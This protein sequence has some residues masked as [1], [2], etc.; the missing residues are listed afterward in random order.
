[1]TDP[2]SIPN[3]HDGRLAV[4]SVGRDEELL[5]LRKQILTEVGV[6][7]RSVSPERA[8]GYARSSQ[9]RLWIFCS[10][11]ELSSLIYLASSVRRYSPQSKLVLLS[12]LNS[13][14]FEAPLF[15]RILSP[16]TGID[17]FLKTV[18]ELSLAAQQANES[19][20]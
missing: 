8:E 20:N 13:A 1:M 14:K 3:R 12:G 4:I 6:D 15:H 16:F 7:V 9:P 5:E 18:D 17:V 2:Q 19:V 10:S 11:V